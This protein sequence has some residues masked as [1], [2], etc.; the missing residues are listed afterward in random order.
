M[1]LMVGAGS[2]DVLADGTIIFRELT[3]AI[4]VTTWDSNIDVWTRCIDEVHGIGFNFVTLGCENLCLTVSDKRGQD[5]RPVWRLLTR[6]PTFL[7]QR[8]MQVMETNGELEKMVGDLGRG[9]R[10]D[11]LGFRLRPML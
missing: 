11:G 1:I 8:L 2:I 4:S 6:V 5:F 3:S 9:A 10:C 7:K